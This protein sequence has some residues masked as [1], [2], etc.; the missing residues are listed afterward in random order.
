MIAVFSMTFIVRLMTSLA[1]I[2][3]NQFFTDSC[4]LR[5]HLLKHLKLILMLAINFLKSFK[6]LAA[7][8]VEEV[9]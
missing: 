3:L 4:L 5:N 6:V 2:G 8:G 7:S 1:G 9:F